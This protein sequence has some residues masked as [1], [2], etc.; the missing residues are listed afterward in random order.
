MRIG[1]G[2]PL[3]RLIQLA[4]GNGLPVRCANVDWRG[5]LLAIATETGLLVLK[6][7]NLVAVLGIGR[8][9]VEEIVVS[10]PLYQ[11]GEPFFLPRVALEHAWDGEALFV[12]RKR[13][14]M[15][16]ALTWYLSALSI[17][18]ALA[19]GLLLV[20]TT[21]GI[22]EAGRDAPNRDKLGVTSQAQSPAKVPLNGPTSAVAATANDSR[23]DDVVVSSA[24]SDTQNGTETPPPN[25]SETGNSGWAGQVQREASVGPKASSVGFDLIIGKGQASEQQNLQMHLPSTDAAS[26]APVPINAAPANSSGIVLS[27]DEVNALL[28][29]ADA[30]ITKGDVAAARLLYE[31]AADAADQQ[32]ALRLAESYDP[33]FLARAHLSGARGDAAAAARWY[34]RALE[35]GS[36]EAEALLKTVVP[37]KDQKLP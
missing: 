19:G 25:S 33:A 1:D 20:H 22:T 27:L 4:K 7:G 3:D 36:A 17:C 32:A 5:L 24:P 37:V 13:S 28:T 30:L 16:R 14:K 34:R 2:V 10:D 9:G 12:R 15:E 6:N 18:G 8:D 31:H 35:L 11:G 21:I 23:P 29:R 26:A